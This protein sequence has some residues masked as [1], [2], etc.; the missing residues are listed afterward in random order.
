M[1]KFHSFFFSRSSDRDSDRATDRKKKKKKRRR[2]GSGYNSELQ[3]RSE[4]ERESHA[5]KY[6]TK[7]GKCDN[8][9][10]PE[11]RWRADGKDVRK[12][13]LLQPNHTSQPNGSAHQRCNGYMGKTRRSIQTVLQPSSQCYNTSL[14]TEASSLTSRKR[15][16]PNQRWRP[17]FQ[18]YT[19]PVSWRPFNDVTEVTSATSTWC[20]FVGNIMY[21]CSN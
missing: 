3:H 17:R 9:F 21:F 5:P 7:G 13:H 1:L 16:L 12:G 10:Y 4:R 14:L 20:F 19:G 18:T 8:G 15:L 2:H 11:K 6:N